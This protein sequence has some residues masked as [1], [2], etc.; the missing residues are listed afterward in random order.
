LGGGFGGVYTG[1]A[2]ERLLR[3]DP[4]VEV[5]LVNKENYFTFQ[6][7]LAEVVSGD[8]G[9]LDTV[10]PLHR[11]LPRTQLCIREI[12]SV[13]LDRK[14]VTLAPGFW[15]RP[16]VLQY[17]QLVLALGTVTDFR[18]I[19]GIHEHALPFKTLADALT[20]RN[21]LI[22]VLQE[23][24]LETDA[25]R[26]AELL[27]FV[28]AGGG[29]SGVE[30][31]AELNDFVR[32]AARKMQGLSRAEIRVLLVH[33]GERVLERELKPELSLYAQKIMQ[34]RGIELLLKCRLRTATPGAAVLQDGQRIKTKTLVSTVPSSTNPLVE[35]LDLPKI[36]GKIKVNSCLEVEGRP[37]VWA[38][39]DCI[40]MAG[41]NG[42]EACPP[43]AQCATRAAKVLAGNLVAC[44]RGGEPAP[45]VFKGLGKLGS[46]GHR[47]AVAQ[48]FNRVPISG[49]LAWFMWRT[50][51][52]W[53]LPGL[54]RKIR[55]GISWLLDLL[56][57]PE[58]VQLKAGASQ[59]V[60]Q[61]HYEPG[62]V[63]FHQG[64]LGDCLYII[65]SGEAEAVIEEQGQVRVLARIKAGEYFGE[66]A[67]LNRGTRTATVRCTTAMSVLALRQGDFHALVGN[68]PELRRSFERVMQNRIDADR[69]SA[70]D[71]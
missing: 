2:L 31:A 3:R 11:L 4:S 55:V 27:T 38:I 61:L 54:D 47:S 20:L 52:W 28:I 5:V 17:D 15:P 60:S 46:L 41:S 10:S 32:G 23:A 18:E 58:T 14:T 33:S 53:K 1:M 21:H 49:M 36:K 45:F 43:T 12:Q 68:L 7:M 63:V 64:D 6:P 9:I 42:T 65:L 24:T 56:L 39:G 71:D 35:Q 37:G 51:Y 40:A 30:V 26:R 25:E 57:P 34:K 70:T 44:L 8:I 19:P 50:V 67:L 66:M 62:E 69:A 59:A 48:L 13:D 22:H 16:L 29:F